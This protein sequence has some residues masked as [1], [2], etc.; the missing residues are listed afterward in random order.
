MSDPDPTLSSGPERSVPVEASAAA[1]PSRGRSVAAVVCLVLATLLTTPAAIAYWGQRTL[2]D[3]TRY[4]NTVGPLVDSPEVQNAIATTVTDAIEKQVDIEAILNDVF[5]GVITD[6][7]RLQRLVGPLSASINGLID[8]QVREFLASDEFADLWIA[9]NTRVQQSLQRLLTGD[10][11]G[12]VSLQGDQVVLDVSEVIERV[13]QRLVDRGLTVV[14][15]VP[16][17]NIDKQIV[18]M[19]AP[20]LAKLRTI[21]AFANP[22][23]QWMLVAVAGL[24][25]A[26]LLLARRRPRMTVIIGAVLAANA[27]L[28]A[29]ALAVGRQLFIDALSG[30]KFG[31]ASAVFYDTLLAY[32]D[33][34]RQVF[35]WLGLILVVVG[36]FAGPNRY[37]TAVR[38]AVSGGLESIGGA[39]ADSPVGDVGR[40]VAPNARWLRVAVGLLGVVVLLW[41]NDISPSRL[42]WSLVLVV[43]LLAVVQVLVGAGRAAVAAPPIP[44]A[45]AVPG[46]AK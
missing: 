32:L 11:S 33:R 22:L 46:T 36:W 13:K 9:V 18:L 43:G 23:A 15:N 4:V 8:R 40:W 37:G 16:I 42:F 39:L 31:P 30:T 35:L 25:L 24:Y 5:A 2:N 6:R 10:Q 34:G 14:Q 19:E 12:A 17:P 45:Q 27:L 20:E 41:G 29:L 44:P 28:V 21:Y 3:T 26:A 1:R 7:P 38:T